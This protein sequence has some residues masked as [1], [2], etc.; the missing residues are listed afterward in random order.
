MDAGS[1]F[2]GLYWSL[3][4]KPA[5]VPSPA[6]PNGTQKKDA[7]KGESVTPFSPVAPG[8]CGWARRGDRRQVW[9][10]AQPSDRDRWRSGLVALQL[11]LHRGESSDCKRPSALGPFKAE[12]CRQPQVL[13][14]CEAAH[15]ARRQAAPQLVW[16]G[17]GGAA[18]PSQGAGARGRAEADRGERS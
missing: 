3:A 9:E 10:A 17:V 2:P 4:S 11:P 15:P 7:L 8:C 13:L 1:S 16:G 18:E 14:S 5:K 12:S 6:E